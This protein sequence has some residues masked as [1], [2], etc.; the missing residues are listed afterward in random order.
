MSGEQGTDLPVA[1]A[2]AAS[3]N[4]K[5]K[6]VR[7][8]LRDR[9]RQLQNEH[10]K[11]IEVPGYGGDLIARY[12]VMSPDDIKRA[13]KLVERLP[14]AE[15]LNVAAI[16]Q[17]IAACD[18]LWTVDPSDPNADEN[19]LVP[20]DPATPDLRFDTRL[21]AW[22]GFEADSAR[23][24]VRAIFTVEG[25]VNMPAIL[26]HSSKIGR[27]MQDVSQEVDGAFVGE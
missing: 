23:G 7:D 24:T 17:I 3:T 9:H 2:A 26:D 27:W 6:S 22:F 12:K 13:S 21:A 18:S 11:D 1:V 8:R 16:D 19:G 5:G 25:V 10:H 15:R 4:P 20:L 14:E